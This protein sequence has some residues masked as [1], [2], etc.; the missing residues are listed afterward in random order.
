[1]VSFLAAANT[2]IG[3]SGV[4]KIL[5]VRILTLISGTYHGIVSHKYLDYKLVN[6]VQILIVL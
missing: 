6:W 5:S 2:M 3:V 1:M 4:V